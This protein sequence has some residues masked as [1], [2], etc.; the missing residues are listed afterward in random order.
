MPVVLRLVG[1]VKGEGA[2]YG[3]DPAAFSADL[4]TCVHDEGSVYQL[5]GPCYVD[6]I[7]DGEATK[8][9]GFSPRRICLR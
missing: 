3:N 2:K 7:M 5:V 8:E 9:D 1:R 4:K 6:G